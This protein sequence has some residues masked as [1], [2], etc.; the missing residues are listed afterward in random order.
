[1]TTDQAKPTELLPERIWLRRNP[2][3]LRFGVSAVWSPEREDESDI[4]YTRTPSPAQP[5][6]VGPLAESFDLNASIAEII[7]HSPAQAEWLPIESAP[8]EGRI[9]LGGEGK[10]AEGEWWQIDKMWSVDFEP[11]H[12][13]PRPQPP[14]GDDKQ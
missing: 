2:E 9:I 5:A 11:S 1:M 3:S 13:Q 4:E 14:K 12:W 8:K 7:G 6:R 10:S